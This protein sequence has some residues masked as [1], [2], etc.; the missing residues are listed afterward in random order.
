MSWYYA[1][2]NE[3]R[4]PIEDAAFQ[5]LVAAGT[6]KPETL[7][8]RDGLAEWVPYR[9]AVRGVS[10]TPASPAADSSARVCS[11]CGR[12]FS[13]DEMIEIAGRS[14]CAGCKPLAVQHMIEGTGGAAA[15]GTP[16]DP[17][18]FLADLRARGGY[19]ISVGSVLSRAWATVTANFWPCV[20]VTLLVYLIMGVSQNIPCL[21]ILAPFLLTGPL[22]GGIYLYFLKQLRGQP[23]VVGDAFSGFNQPHFGRLALTGTMATLIVLAVLAV[24]IGPAVALNWD[25]LQSKSEDPPAGFILWCMAALLPV[26]YLTVAW[27]LSYALVIDKGLEF[28]PAMELSRQIVNMNLGGWFVILLV[29]GL[30]MLAGFLVLCVGV[31]VVMPVTVCGLM[32]IY[33]DIFSS[34]PGPAA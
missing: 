22:M 12:L 20:G 30:L 25:A 34:R 28:W 3:R 26:M 14:I 15:G 8:W 19:R 7:V 4:G 32:V 9:E 2:N 16:I 21:G 33:E 1:E 10:G 6:I 13:A 27:M 31:L 29:N 5:A 24:L 23:A 11:H 18:Q 17:V